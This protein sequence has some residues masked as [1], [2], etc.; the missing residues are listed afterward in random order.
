MKL[1]YFLKNKMKIQ[2]KHAKNKRSW[3]QTSLQCQ[4]IGSNEVILVNAEE[5]EI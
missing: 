5:K 3:P 1:K 4:M 2:T